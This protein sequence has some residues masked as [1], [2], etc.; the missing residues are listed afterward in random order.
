MNESPSINLEARTTVVSY[1]GVF[2]L[3]LVLSALAVAAIEVHIH[4][5]HRIF[6]HGELKAII[7]VG[8]LIQLIAQFVYFLHPV[9]GKDSRWNMI[10]FCFMLL[11]VVTIVIGS[12]W[13]MQNL[14][15]RM[16][17]SPAQQEMYMSSQTM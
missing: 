11:F 6:T 17:P 4:S 10:A 16:M 15:G 8:A 2:M 14:N 13:I 3:C 7:V 12:I 1:F 5:G 9:R